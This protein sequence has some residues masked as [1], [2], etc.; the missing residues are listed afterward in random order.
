VDSV[1]ASQEQSSTR[2]P[3]CQAQMAKKEKKYSRRVELTNNSY[4]AKTHTPAV[5]RFSV[6]IFFNLGFWFSVVGFLH[7]FDYWFAS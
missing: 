3:P 5:R 4:S 1:G 2:T 6:F 7:G